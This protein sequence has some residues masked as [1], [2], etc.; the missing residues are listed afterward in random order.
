MWFSQPRLFFT[1]NQCGE[2]CREMDVPLSHRDLLQLAAAMPDS[3]PTH[4]VRLRP[5]HQLHPEALLL[6][7]NY[8]LLFL[9]RKT[10]QDECAFLSSEGS[11]LNYEARPR[12]C[13]SFPFQYTRS[14][15]LQIIPEIDFLYQNFC[16]KDPVSRQ[17]L[18]E[19]G[20]HLVKADREFAEYQ[21]LI[22]RWNRTVA[23]IHTRQTLEHLIVFFQTHTPASAP[24]SG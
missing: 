13:R 12:A 23:R 3:P 19:A 2:C 9:Q 5:S 18:R 24:N 16:S 22:Q 20:A 11:C 6:E 4:Y 10:T 7:G 8:H 17:A 1:C 14:H 21:A 15:Y